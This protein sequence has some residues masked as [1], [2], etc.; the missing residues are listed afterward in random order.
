MKETARVGAAQVAGRLVWMWLGLVL[1]GA[2]G[3]RAA[4]PNPAPKALRPNIIFILADD[5]GYGDLG[6]YGQSR[7][8]TPNLDRMAQQGLRFTSFYAG[9][10][11]GGPSRCALMTGLDT[12][13]ALVRGNPAGPLGANDL[14]VAQLLKQAGYHTGL[15]GKW[16]LGGPNSTGVPH[17]QGFDEFLGCL[18]A[19]EAEDYY[20]A[21]LWRYD[22]V[23]GFDGPEALPQNAA[24]AL[25]LYA[26][27][28]FTHAAL[29]YLQ[30]H[31]PASYTHDRPFFLYL[32]YSLPHANNAEAKR[33][34]NGMQVPSDAPYST[35]PWPQVE[36]DKAAM[37]TRLDTEVGQLLDAL[38]QLKLDE[39]TIVFFSSDN[40][41]AHEGGAHP[42][43]FQSSGPLR[44]HKGSLYEGGIR[45]P[46]LVRWPGRIKPGASDLPAALWDFLPTAAE[47]AGTKAPAQTDGISLLPT[48]LGQTQTNRH[49]FLYWESH[50]GG[51]QQAVRMGD[52]KALRLKPGQPLE[53]Y[54][55]KS[56]PSERTNVAGQN[57]Q[58]VAR[59]EACLKTARTDS[60]LWP[61]SPASAAPTR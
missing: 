26:P 45:V 4:E 28:L 27:D 40:G 20:P 10:P 41:P 11:L 30:I 8:Q 57:P 37:V 55:L 42:R 22:P 14:T 36:K 56:D 2:L 43:F 18:D 46:L 54:N 47:L 50:Q 51:F 7:L 61:V 29:H 1:A 16:G 6:C 39:N 12:G 23:S 13:H 21:R 60:A 52:W 48:L 35:Q 3:V 34:G 58:V 44:G 49:D 15:I 19:L 31:K 38:K 53:L 59:I 25:G 33:S 9:A 17:R 24:G 32:A 5:L